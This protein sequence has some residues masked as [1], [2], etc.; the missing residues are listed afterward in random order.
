MSWPRILLA[1]AIVFLVA[2]YLFGHFG[3]EDDKGD[4]G[5]AS[6]SSIRYLTE[7]T[8]TIETPVADLSV[9]GLPQPPEPEI[10]YSSTV[11]SSTSYYDPSTT[12]GVST[13]TTPTPS[14]S[15]STSSGSRP[16]GGSFGP[17]N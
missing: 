15:T 17:S 14:S 12:S 16:Y 10:T 1:T 3:P 5:L 4:S 13:S 6:R 11:D 8:A 2:G 7:P 9:P